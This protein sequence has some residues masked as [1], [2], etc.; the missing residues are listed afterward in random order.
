MQEN[1]VRSSS[2]L[3]LLLSPELQLVEAMVEPALCQELPMASALSDL[4]MLEHQNLVRMEDGAQTVCHH[5]AGAARHQLRDGPLDL[6]LGFGIYR[7]GCLIQNQ[8]CGIQCQ[9]PREAQKLALSDTEAA[10]AFSQAM[11]V[12]LWEPFDESV[13][14][15]P[16]RGQ[17]R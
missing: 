9:R 15:N 11:A 10:P 12:P 2:D 3:P 6:A 4:A 7:A 5:E 16:V 1:E 8:D 14:S 13:G 17:T